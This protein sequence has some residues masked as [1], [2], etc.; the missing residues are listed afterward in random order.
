MS[1]KSGAK[2]EEAVMQKIYSI[3]CAEIIAIGILFG[4]LGAVLSGKKES[5]YYNFNYKEK[6]GAQS[7]SNDYHIPFGQ[8]DLTRTLAHNNKKNIEEKV[9]KPISAPE[10]DKKIRQTLK[11]RK[12]YDVNGDG[13]VDCIDYA[14][15]FKNTW[16]EAE[17]PYKCELVW[18]LNFSTNLSHLFVRVGNQET[19]WIYVESWS[20]YYENYLMEDV[21]GKIYDP[22]YNRDGSRWRY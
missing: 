15:V 12:V 18:N 2:Q 3:I 17:S 13:N 11:Q 19:G 16:E 4:I 6:A 9:I 5:A 21:W 1:G 22:K 7:T 8:T 20:K 10:L 14:N